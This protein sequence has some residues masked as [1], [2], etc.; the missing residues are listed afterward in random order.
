MIELVEYFVVKCNFCHRY[1]PMKWIKTNAKKCPS[2]GEKIK[3]NTL[4][5]KKV[6]TQERARKMAMM[7]NEDGTTESKSALD[8]LRGGSNR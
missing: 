3:W 6:K 4:P 8:Y 1:F 2:C 5:R 7:L